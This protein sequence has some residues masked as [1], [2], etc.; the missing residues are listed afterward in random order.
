[1]QNL[2]LVIHIP[3][4]LRKNAHGQ[5][6]PSVGSTI[7]LFFYTFCNLNLNEA[8]SYSCSELVSHNKQTL[9]LRSR[10]QLVD[11]IV[12]RE[13]SLKGP[14]KGVPTV[15]PWVKNLVVPQLW[16]RLL[17]LL[18]IDPWP[19][20]FYMPHVWPKNKN[21][22]KEKEGACHTLV[23][24]PF[25]NMFSNSAAPKN[26]FPFGSAF[27]PKS[28]YLITLNSFYLSCFFSPS[29][30]FIFVQYNIAYVFRFRELFFKFCKI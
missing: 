16:C 3:Y 29:T 24:C 14:C 8:L 13:I 28:S 25:H 5:R 6:Q 12:H 1:M 7:Y 17:L 20:N 2:L 4:Y 30:Q 9:I 22:N 27:C 15:A 11:A 23:L 21:K 18:G 26:Q 10:L 19:G